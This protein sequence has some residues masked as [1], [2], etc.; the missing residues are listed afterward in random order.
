MTTI[1]WNEANAAHLLRRAAFGGTPQQI[2]RAVSDGLDLTVSKLLDYSTISTSELDQRIERQKL[3]L[4]TFEGIS[5]WWLTRLIHS[6]RPLEERLTLFW[7]DHFAT[8]I[9]K[10]EDAAL[11]L[12]QNELIRSHALSRF[13]DLTTEISKDRAML[14]WLDN[15]TSRREHPN[16]NFGRELLELFT[17]GQGFYSELDVDAA[18]RAF[19]GWTFRHDTLDFLF[20]PEW[21]DDAPK[22]FL[23]RVG[24]WDGDDIIRIACSEFAHGR[25]IASKVFAY[26]AYENPEV[27]V[28]D[29]LAQLYLDSGTDIRVLV[30]AILRSPEMYSPRALWSRVKSPVDHAVIAFRQLQLDNDNLVWA[31]PSALTNQGQTLFDPPD[32]AGWDTGL[33]W[34]NSGALLTRMN[35]ASALARILTP[36]RFLAGASASTPEQL[37]DI[38][39]SRLGPLTVPV[40]VHD[41]LTRYVS[42]DATMP[43]GGALTMKQRGLAH[44]VLSLPEWQM[45]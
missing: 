18:V 22:D 27:S 40:A 39:L 6:P 4:R 9:T 45:Y 31:L 16:Q 14:I 34:M 36:S 7:H 24:N 29:P 23:G 8:G 21:H 17:L 26:F 19:T 35:I 30:D 11:M 28:I 38:Y 3:D 10:V 37:V 1:P 33:A 32:V 15:H 20:I 44:L 43:T 5:R 41:A 2:A 42:A 12:K 25:L 13:T